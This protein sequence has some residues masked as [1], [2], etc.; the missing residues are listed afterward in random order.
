MVNLPSMPLQ[1]GDSNKWAGPH[2]AR[3]VTSLYGKRTAK[4][5]TDTDV[6][7]VQYNQQKGD[8]GKDLLVYLLLI[9]LCWLYTREVNATY[10]SF[11]S[12]FS[13]FAN[14]DV[15]ASQQSNVSNITTIDK[16]CLSWKYKQMRNLVLS[17]LL[18]SNTR[19]NHRH[20]LYACLSYLLMPLVE[21]SITSSQLPE[22]TYLPVQ[23]AFYSVCLHLRPI[24]TQLAGWPGNFRAFCRLECSPLNIS[25]FSPIESV[26]I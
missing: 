16:F 5:N 4:I 23:Q 3:L 20:E 1:N 8:K 11:G 17:K 6:T 12:L 13:F 7:R 10:L 25:N 21:V 26:K 19:L 22:V 2:H 24:K 9:T 14:V 15:V 18:Q